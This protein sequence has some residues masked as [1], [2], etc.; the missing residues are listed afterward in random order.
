MILRYVVF[1]RTVGAKSWTI[2]FKPSLYK[3]DGSRDFNVP[4]MF[5][6]FDS[7]RKFVKNVQKKRRGWWGGVP[8]QR[9][10]ESKII[11]CVLPS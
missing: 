9:P 3:G 1:E 4:A 11:K 6:R 8:D 5:H 7:A 10:I 2:A